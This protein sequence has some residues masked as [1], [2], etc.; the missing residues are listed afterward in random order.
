MKKEYNQRINEPYNDWKYRLL[1][2]KKDNEIDLTWKEIRDLLDIDIAPDS[3]RKVAAAVSEYRDYVAKINSDMISEVFSELDKKELEM[4][5]EKIRMQDQK[6]ELNKMIREWGR[7]E[8]IENE[9]KKVMKDSLP[10]NLKLKKSVSYTPSETEGVLLLSDWHV[11]QYDDNFKN[12][13]NIAVLKDRLTTLVAQTIEYGKLHKISKLNVFILGDL[14]NGLIHV[15]T[16]I[17]NTEDTVRQ[18][19]TVSEYISDALT[20]LRSEFPEIE[21]YFARGNH[22]RI[23]AKKKESLTYESFFDFIPWYLESKL[24]EFNDIIINHECLGGEII[25]TSVCGNKVVGVHGD[26]E[27]KNPDK[28]VSNLG[29]MLHVIPDYVFMGHYHKAAESE[30]Q[31]VEIIMNG[32]L[33]GPDSYAL[34][35]RKVSRPSQKFMVFTQNGRLCTYNIWLD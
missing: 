25:V 16:R 12:K 26:K 28:I 27:G 5:K 1:L 7:A 34:D 17:N 18:V 29:L 2:G 14:I 23:T 30:V 24:C 10:E 31:G 11:G 35:L 22:E 8:H 3:L 33:C 4:K 13:F 6:R 9:L 20:I 15:T 19:M 21:V 32:C